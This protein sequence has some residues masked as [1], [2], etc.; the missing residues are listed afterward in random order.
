M[1][2]IL[3]NETYEEIFVKVKSVQCNE[4]IIQLLFERKVANSP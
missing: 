3:K 2:W 4:E 1:L